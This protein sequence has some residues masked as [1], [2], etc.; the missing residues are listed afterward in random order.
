LDKFLC[1]RLDLK[2][3]VS[4][5]LDNIH[6]YERKQNGHKPRCQLG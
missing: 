3:P 1:S 6:S 5:Y 2:K 4:S